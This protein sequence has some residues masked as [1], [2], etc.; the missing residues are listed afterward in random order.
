MS[1]Q[2][3]QQ[4]MR[5]HKCHQVSCSNGGGG[6]RRKETGAWAD[7]RRHSQVSD[8]RRKEPDNQHQHHHHCCQAASETRL[9]LDDEGRS[10]ASSASKS[11]QSS[12][13]SSRTSRSSATSSNRLVDDGE[14][15]CLECAAHR[16]DDDEDLEL[17]GRGRVCRRCSG[18]R[19][20][21]A[22][23]PLGGASGCAS[24]RHAATQHEPAS[25]CSSI[26]GGGAN[27][28]ITNELDDMSSSCAAT[29]NASSSVFGRIVDAEAL[30]TVE[31]SAQEDETEQTD[32]AV[33]EDELCNDDDD[34]DN[35]SGLRRKLWSGHTTSHQ[36]DRTT[37]KGCGCKA[38]AEQR[39]ARTIAGVHARTSSKDAVSH[40]KSMLECQ[41]SCDSAGLCIKCGAQ[42]ARA[43]ASCMHPAASSRSM[44]CNKASCGDAET[45][46][47]ASSLLSFDGAGRP[48]QEARATPSKVKASPKQQ[49][50]ASQCPT[51]LAASHVSAGQPSATGTT[52]TTLYSAN[53]NSVGSLL[54]VQQQQQ[55]Q[56]TNLQTLPT[57]TLNAHQQ[58]QKLRNK[59][60]S[61]A[62][63]ATGRGSRATLLGSTAIP[64][65]VSGGQQV[66]NNIQATSSSRTMD[67]NR[68]TLMLVVVVTVFLIV[69]VPVALVTIA[70]VV[71]NLF[72][73][74]RDVEVSSWL[75]YIKLFTNFFIMISYSVNFTI[76][77]SMSKKFRETFRDLFFCGR[78]SES[79]HAKRILYQSQ[80]AQSQ[81][82]P[83]TQNHHQFAPP[84]SSVALNNSNSGY[85]AR[86]QARNSVIATTIAA[87]NH[88]NHNHLMSAPSA[89]AAAHSNG[90]SCEF[91]NAKPADNYLQQQQQKQQKKQQRG[92]THNEHNNKK[93][94]P[95][96]QSAQGPKCD[97]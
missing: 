97:V 50:A 19:D 65:I 74:F 33:N 44:P 9:S 84:A 34:D 29:Q 20:E 17:G 25:Q 96:Q 91:L 52:S 13:S 18:T 27:T 11:D 26:L 76:Y 46:D 69:E 47:S 39:A 1:R 53:T 77:C 68:T 35:N 16:E 59:S 70:H 48:Q 7:T 41:A 57:S 54:Q 55:Q 51:T 67:S 75:E 85:H 32:N 28:S 37:G 56:A 60:P 92:Q 36:R 38:V 78:A 8:A 88:T 73:V 23:A 82:E 79:K 62:S 86:S 71:L 14:S 21:Q 64:L 24:N 3:Q 72:D 5:L 6:G 81:Y 2:Q 66:G 93:Q 4:E 61:Y 31:A 22:A 89:R 40:S 94:I 90:R 95:F 49:R 80:A 83:Y 30:D 63:C 10:W 45:R 42:V 12:M 15:V 43:H 87:N 58:Q